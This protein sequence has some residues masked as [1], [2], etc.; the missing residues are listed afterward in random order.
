MHINDVRKHQ[1]DKDHLMRT[2]GKHPA[3]SI[4]AYRSSK[5]EAEDQ[6]RL[7]EERKDLSRMENNRKYYG[8]GE[9][10]HGYMGGG[11]SDKELQEKRSDIARHEKDEEMY[12]RN[13]S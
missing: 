8:G 6:E 2:E 10:H 11:T 4:K 3:N 9:K 5:G 13:K 1:A 7:S 12:A